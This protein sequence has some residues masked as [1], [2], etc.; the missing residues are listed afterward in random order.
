MKRLFLLL[1]GIWGISSAHAESITGKC[2]HVFDGDSFAVIK[3]GESEQT[4][5]RLYGIDAP[6]KGQEYAKQAREKL[7]KLV[8]HK[9]VRIEVQNTDDYGRQ[10]GKVYVG[11]TYVNLEMVKAGLAWHYEH[12]AAKAKDL[13]KAEAKARKAKKGLWQADNPI[14][15]R[16]WRR[17]HN[18]AHETKVSPAAT[19]TE[20]TVCGTCTEVK[21]GEE[22]YLRTPGGTKMHIYLN[23][24]DAPEQE[25]APAACQAAKEAL[26]ELLLNKKVSVRIVNA[27]NNRH[28][29]AV[30]V[31]SRYINAEMVSRGL[32]WYSS[33]HAPDDAELKA[34][35]QAARTAKTGFW[36]TPGAEAPW[37]WRKRNQNKLPQ[38]E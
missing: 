25:Q 17:D 20:G 6:E 15:P 21:D 1:A 38:S 37:K 29:A 19:P 14:N 33:L 7:I 23:G 16:D 26:Q 27:N 8:R 9:Q 5:I 31:G 35:A 30:Y 13:K 4:Q 34:A 32:T 12:H 22:F 2:E 10:I 11:K 28:Y 24:T 18:T 36:A 3:T